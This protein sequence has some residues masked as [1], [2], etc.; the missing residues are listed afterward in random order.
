[1]LLSGNHPVTHFWPFFSGDIQIRLLQC[2]LPGAASE[3]AW[4][5]AVL[6]IACLVSMLRICDTDSLVGCSGL[7]FKRVG[8]F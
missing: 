5:A 6:H 2:A 8:M 7:M 4:N 3:D 1:M